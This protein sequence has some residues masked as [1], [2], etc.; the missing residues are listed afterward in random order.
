MPSHHGVTLWHHS[1][2]WH[3]LLQVRAQKK[4]DVREKN[5]VFVRRP[6]CV[7]SLFLSLSQEDN[8]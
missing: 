5:L 1:M 7:S 3:V 8:N 2:A 4:A 6:C